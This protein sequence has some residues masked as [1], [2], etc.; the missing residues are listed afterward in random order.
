MAATAPAPPWIPEDD[1]L[2]K[3]AIEA[4][5]T[6]EALAKGAV[7][8]SRKFTVRELRE[9]W[10][11]LLYDADV[12]AEASSRMVEFEACG[13]NVVPCK[14][15][16]FSSQSRGSK[17]KGESIRKQYYALKKRLCA[18]SNFG[19]LNDF[20]I[21][22]LGGQAIG[23]QGTLDANCMVGG[24]V[25]PVFNGDGGSVF[26]G[27]E[28]EA[29][30]NR[31]VDGVEREGCGNEFLEPVL[32]VATNG[33]GENAY[34]RDNSVHEDLSTRGVNAMDYGNSLDTE[35]IGAH[36][37]DVA[38][39]EMP[40][41]ETLVVANDVDVDGDTMDI[42]DSSQ[43]EVG[44]NEA[45]LV[46]GEGCDA[47]NRAAAISGGDYGD[48]ADSLFN[49]EVNSI[50][51]SS[52]KD[53]HDDDVPEFC[54]PGMLVSASF[55]IVSNDLHTAE[56]AVSVEPSQTGHDDLRD[57]FCSDA[58][59]PSSSTSIPLNPT[60]MTV[61]PMVHDAPEMAVA[62]EV[63]EEMV[64]SLNTEDLDIPCN[65]DIV[66][67]TAIVHTALQ[68]SSNEA[69]NLGTDQ[70]KCDQ[71]I[72]TLETKEDPA[73]PFRKESPNPT[74]DKNDLAAASQCRLA[75][76]TLNCITKGLLNE[77][78]INVP[79]I[80]AELASLTVE[81]GSY[82]VAFPE[83][84]TNPTA[85]DCEESEEESD[86]DV[87]D[88][89]EDTD[90]PYY[91][92]IETMIL[93]MDLCPADE[94]SDISRRVLKYQHEDAKRNIIRLEQCAQ[95]SMRRAL[96]SKGTLAVLYDHHVKHYIKK[97]EVIIGRTTE[98]NQVDIDLGD[99]KVSRRQA[100]IKMDADGSFSLKNLGK[101]SIFLNG[102]EIATGKILNFASSNLIEIREMAF[103]FEINHISVKQYLA[104]IATKSEGHANLELAPEGVS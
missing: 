9:R 21:N 52:P 62:P 8:F 26:H 60:E 30:K 43:Y 84:Q 100:L 15:N 77:E 101:S 54:E 34:I 67:F 103:V 78:E 2:L 88:D 3:N 23:N 83:P 10:R 68:P 18:D 33:L 63:P 95:S 76:A 14:S 73:Q 29:L 82:N 53:V 91:S 4:G 20:D 97:T 49:D 74:H 37:W 72:K 16:R 32:L 102:R 57:I 25:E 11:S 1:L 42:M 98:D 55:E 46:D 80:V 50:L 47:L 96:T 45:M 36:L 7:R 12:A 35:D 94:E 38:A 61:A 56:M 17:R 59:M 81:P 89:E 104:K 40:A 13:S 93:E 6:L 70:R 5:A 65:D 22:F 64:C 28:C 99:N 48:M 44:H 86:D 69:S 79:G 71:H 92:D 19:S 39:P 31:G 27:G 41:E 87:D 51:L 75:D 58:N 90:I 85:L 24:G 66:F